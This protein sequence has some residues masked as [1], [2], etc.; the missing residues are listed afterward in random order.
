METLRDSFV[1]NNGI[2]M[3]KLGLGTF[4]STD[5]LEIQ[6]V[7][8][9][10]KIGYRHIDTA[11]AYD[12]EEGIGKA[13]RES[14]IPREDIFVVSK[15]RNSD[16]GYES[17][18]KAFEGTIERLGLDY[19]DLYLI[20]W[21]KPTSKDTWRAMEEIY[22]SG[23]VKA[24]GVSNFK[25]H[26]L[27][28]LMSSATV[29]PA[30]NQVEYHVRLQQDDLFQYCSKHKIQL[31]AYAPL[32]QGQIL[33]IPLLKD[34]A[35]RYNKSVAQIALRWIIQ[36]GIV[37]IPKSVKKHRLEENADI[38]DFALS[39]EDMK[40]ISSLDEHRRIYSDPDDKYND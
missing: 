40:Q 17:T 9:A 32:M 29:T 19:L 15:V 21:P 10:L 23:R 20:H 4:K 11:K 1:L 18:L 37:A 3:P 34:L 39:G 25:V 38:F 31:E 22:K 12:N 36:K 13:I 16:Q 33:D 28:D 14:N 6:A 8:D 30:I 26:H 24:I 7:S 35:Q 5:G 27:E 2:K